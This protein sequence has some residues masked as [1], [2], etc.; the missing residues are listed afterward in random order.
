MCVKVVYKAVKS[1]KEMHDKIYFFSCT[2]SMTSYFIDI[3]MI[4]V[5]TVM[6]D[7]KKKRIF[8]LYVVSLWTLD[9]FREHD[10][11]G[12]LPAAGFIKHDTILFT[13]FMT[14]VDVCYITYN[15]YRVCLI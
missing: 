14:R 6:Y 13:V 12:S 8:N 3:K 2:C 9:V 10:I 4:Q 5:W 7:N 11:T 1:Y 15:R